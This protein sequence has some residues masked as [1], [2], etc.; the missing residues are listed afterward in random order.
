MKSYPALSKKPDYGADV[1]RIDNT[2]RFKTESGY[3]ITRSKFSFTPKTIR[4]KYEKLKSSD[5]QLFESLEA[6]IKC[7]K[8]FY[9]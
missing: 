9:R 6:S 8:Q 2:F 1:E 5:V 3:T 7:S 4:L